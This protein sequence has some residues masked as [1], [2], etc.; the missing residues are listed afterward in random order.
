[1]RRSTL[2]IDAPP[3][4]VLAYLADPR[5]R[6][7][8]QPSLRRVVLLD[9]GP[10]RFGQRWVDVTAV[11]IRPRMRTTALAGDRWSERG[12]WRGVSAALG[13]RVRPAGGATALDVELTLRGRGPLGVLLR[14]LEPLA[15]VV[16]RSDLRRA[17]TVLSPA[18]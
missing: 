11:G 6:P 14:L 7:A 12:D 5:N 4:T 15:M 9:D 16:V 17:G 8:W 13:V 2:V 3:G 1:V 10:P 18:Q